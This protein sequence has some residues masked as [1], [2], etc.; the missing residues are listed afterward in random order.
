MFTGA[1]PVD[2]GSSIVA[3]TLISSI[4]QG[5]ANQNLKSTVN[6]YRLPA[7]ATWDAVKE[8]YNGQVAGD[9]KSVA[10]LTQEAGMVN[11]IGWQRGGAASEQVLI[12]GQAADPV[13]GD[14]FLVLGLFSE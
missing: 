8:F 10:E 2:A 1:E 3:G 5:M 9:W 7:G 13:S 4:E 11:I 12:A 6:L 14:N